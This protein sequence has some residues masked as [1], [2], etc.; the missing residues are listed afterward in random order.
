MHI[1]E[2]LSVLLSKESQQ[3]A[4]VCTCDENAHG[5]LYSYEKDYINPLQQQDGTI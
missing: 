4:D 1:H 2:K 5:Y 3:Q